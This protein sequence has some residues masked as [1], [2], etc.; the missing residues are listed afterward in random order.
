MSSTPTHL[1]VARRAIVQV[2]FPLD[3]P[4]WFRLFLMR[5]HQPLAQ[6]INLIA[7]YIQTFQATVAGLAA[8]TTV[9]LPAAHVDVNYVVSATPDW[10]TTLWVN[11][12]T[13]TGFDANYGTIAP[14]GGGLLYCIAIF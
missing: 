9:V 5:Y 12:L 3:T 14:V 4:D 1:F 10:N 2:P 13:K 6:Q 11:N 7:N 8:S